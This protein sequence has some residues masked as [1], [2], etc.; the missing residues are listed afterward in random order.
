MLEVVKRVYN[1]YAVFSGRESRK[2]FWFF[3]LF[4]AL[5]FGTTVLL[6]LTLFSLGLVG[7]SGV[8][9][10]AILTGINAVVALFTLATIIPAVAQHSRRF[11][12]SNLSAWWLFLALVPG[13]GVA[14]VYAMALIP[15]TQGSSKFEF[16]CGNHPTLE[17]GQQQF[18]TNAP[19]ADLW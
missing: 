9:L 13:V 17:S 3:Q 6:N 14:V 1:N 10:S 2:D 11:H 15:S 16:E 12:D 4:L 7:A 5:V 8:I 18:A 19:G